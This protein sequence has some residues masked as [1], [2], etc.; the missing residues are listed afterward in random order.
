M[1]AQQEVPTA[2]PT[3]AANAPT[4]GYSQQPEMSS[5]EL[6]AKKLDELRQIREANR[7]KESEIAMLKKEV[8]W[9]KQ[10]LRERSAEGK[11]NAVSKRSVP[12]RKAAEAY[13]VR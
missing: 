13:P 8:E 4:A 7:M 6:L 2:T 12:K 3:F 9:M 1:P 11:T 5:D 10:E